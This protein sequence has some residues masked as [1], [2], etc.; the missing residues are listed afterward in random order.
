MFMVWN[1]EA[2]KRNSDEEYCLIVREWQSA[3]EMTEPKEF[4]KSFQELT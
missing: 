2:L 1:N 4:M 3:D